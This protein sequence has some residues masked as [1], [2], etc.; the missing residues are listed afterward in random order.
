M[1][2]YNSLYMGRLLALLANV[3]LGWKWLAE[4]NSSHYDIKVS[5][6]GVKGFVVLGPDLL[7]EKGAMTLSI[8]TLSIMDL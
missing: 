1:E 4:I 5:V 8:T 6:T 2:Y 7:V 3:G